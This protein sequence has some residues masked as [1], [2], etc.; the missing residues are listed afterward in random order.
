MKT[1]LRKFP[2]VSFTGS[3]VTILLIAFLT[4][5]MLWIGPDRIG[6]GVIP[7]LLLLPIGWG[8]ARWGQG[9]GILAAI[10]ATAAFDFFFIPPYFTFS[11]GSLEG[12]LVLAIFLLVAVVIIGRIQLGL[13]QARNSEKE[14]IF[15]YEISTALAGQTSQ[16]SIAR[17]L[18][19]RIC[20]LFLA[21]QVEVT[22]YSERQGSMF[23][24][25]V[26]DGAR[27]DTQ[28]D[29]DIAL[30]ANRNVEGEIHIWNGRLPLPGENSRLMAAY[31][32]QGAF[33]L[34]RARLMN[35]K[36]FVVG[37]QG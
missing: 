8:T 27:V 4:A 10:V 26:P 28:P 25:R 24:V 37:S 11:I 22:V 21:S 19:E 5:G 18:A 23:S 32:K 20:D 30:I 35:Q 12:W 15:M 17:I 14:A 7:L 9:V 6:A 29:R 3:M 34:E 31:A 16:E 13:S 2:S 33:A 36:L 1:I